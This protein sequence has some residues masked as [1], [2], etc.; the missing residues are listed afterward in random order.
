MPTGD[1]RGMAERIDDQQN[2][3]FPKRGVAPFPGPSAGIVHEGWGST[4]TRMDKSIVVG[5]R[6]SVLWESGLGLGKDE[7]VT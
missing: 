6:A 7:S 3:E 4:W 5:S 1:I 2:R